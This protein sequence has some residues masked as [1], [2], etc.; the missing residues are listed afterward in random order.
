[1][2]ANYT[3]ECIAVVDNNVYR[4]TGTLVFNFEKEEDLGWKIVNAK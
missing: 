4:R 3:L 1:V 2:E